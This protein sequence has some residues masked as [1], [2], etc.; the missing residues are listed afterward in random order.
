MLFAFAL[1]ARADQGDESRMDPG[2]SYASRDRTEK[3][4]RGRDHKDNDKK[5]KDDR[6][7]DKRY[8]RLKRDW[9]SDFIDTDFTK[10]SF[11]DL[12]I[13][14]YDDEDDDDDDSLDDGRRRDD[15]SD[16]LDML[17]DYDHYDRDK[18]LMDMRRDD[19]RKEEDR[20]VIK[21]LTKPIPGILH[22][23]VPA[24]ADRLQ[25][26]AFE[27]E[28]DNGFPVPYKLN[29]HLDIQRKLPWD[30]EAP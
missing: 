20:K 9:I 18:H 12:D 6:D 13:N 30:K 3:D 24:K 29:G 23:W 8:S 25:N 21:E 16:D 22:D 11:R 28:P 4:E 7:D 10:K 19:K 15:R 26:G 27:K 5:R 1:S 2:D 14:K 17:S